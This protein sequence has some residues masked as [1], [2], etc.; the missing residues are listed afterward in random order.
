MI[1]AATHTDVPDLIELG[2]MMHAE[3]PR[4]R[5][6]MFRPDKL[7]AMARPLMDNGIVLLAE[8]RGRVVGMAIG[9]V[10]EQFFTDAKLAVDLAVYVVPSHRGGPWFVKLIK[11]F[12]AKAV[13]LGAAEITL[14]IST[15]LQTERTARLYE[16]MGYRRSSVGMVKDV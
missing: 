5:R 15:G 8:D 10:I 14:G 16:K 12:E 4:F 7:E 1:R 2:A 9:A 13:E 3:S 11:A 6:L